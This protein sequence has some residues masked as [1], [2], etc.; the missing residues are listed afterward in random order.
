MSNLKI[1]PVETNQLFHKKYRYSVRF[2]LPELG[3]IRG[4]ELDNIDQVVKERNEWRAQLESRYSFGNKDQI[5]DTT[6]ENLRDMCELLAQHKDQIKFVISF[7]RGYVYTNDSVLVKQIAGKQT[8]TR[9]QVQEAKQICPEGT[10][11]LI[12]PKWTHRT[13]FKSKNV[14]EF[15]RNSLTEYL[16]SRENVRLSPGLKEWITNSRNIN[17][18][19]KSWTHSHFFIDHNN[20][21]EVLFMNMVIP[22]ITG[23]TLQIVAK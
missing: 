19:W 11:A 18:W 22:N 15:Q 10:I 9:V 1:K 8:V 7:D 3:I 14:S 5:T 23:R 6:K 4:L 20:D 12:D 16:A 17:N 13:Y 21:G 2:D